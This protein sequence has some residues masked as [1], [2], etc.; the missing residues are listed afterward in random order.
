[1]WNL[2]CEMWN[3]KFKYIYVETD[4]DAGVV[5]DF[6]LVGCGFFQRMLAGWRYSI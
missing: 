1:M 3:L 4:T 5:V 6:T 2:K